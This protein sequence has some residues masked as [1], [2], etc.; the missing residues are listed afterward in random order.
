MKRTFAILS[1]VL[2]MTFAA[3]AQTASQ[4]KPEQLTKKQLN[5]LI[6]SAKTPAEHNRIATYYQAKSADF[7]AQAKEHESM[8]A[9]YKANTFLSSDKNRASTID[10]CEY[11][12]TTFN[13]LAGNSQELAKLHQRMASEAPETMTPT[14]K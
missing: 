2:V 12:V 7:L 4:A 10:H 11:F 1:L 6:A 9:A 3:V 14:G 5:T 13:A 8:V